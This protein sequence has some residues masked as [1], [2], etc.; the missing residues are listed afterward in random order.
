MVSV[1]RAHTAFVAPTNTVF[2]FEKCVHTFVLS[3]TQT[4][5]LDARPT[6]TFKTRLE[7]PDLRTLSNYKNYA[8]FQNYGESHFSNNLNTS[9]ITIYKSNY[10]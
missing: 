7:V 3:A 9:Y 4:S 5:K 1:H 8:H 6:Q 2:T 10:C